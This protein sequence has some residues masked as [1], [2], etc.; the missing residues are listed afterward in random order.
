MERWGSSYLL[1]DT[2]PLKLVGGIGATTD[3]DGGGQIRLS[4]VNTPGVLAVTVKN[5]LHELVIKRELA[6]Q[7]VTL[8]HVLVLQNKIVRCEDPALPVGVGAKGGF[9]VVGGDP[10]PFICAWETGAT[11]IQYHSPPD[12]EGQAELVI[13]EAAAVQLLSALAERMARIGTS[14]GLSR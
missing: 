10:P 4:F 14:R 12:P 3:D 9:S 2:S 11:G 6:V 5:T 1:H 8:I 13:S 7:L